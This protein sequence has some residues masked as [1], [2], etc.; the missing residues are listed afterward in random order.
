MVRDEFKV[1]RLN[2]EGMKKAEGLAEDFSEFLDRIEQ[3][4]GKEGR[5]M[6]IVRT[7]LQEASFQAKRAIAQRPENQ[8]ADTRIIKSFDDAD[9]FV[10]KLLTGGE[11][12]F[13]VPVED[14]RR[15]G[16]LLKDLLDEVRK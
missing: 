5:E 12:D 10:D 14:A 4:C 11:E 9:R 7:K 1:H 2:D 3:T 6:A 13:R 16:S 8:Q 15:M